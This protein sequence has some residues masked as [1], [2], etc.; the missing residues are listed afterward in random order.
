MLYLL[1]LVDVYFL[2]SPGRN[3]FWENAKALLQS[4]T[5]V[6][7]AQLICEGLLQ[8]NKEKHWAIKTN[9]QI[10]NWTLTDWVS[11]MAQWGPWLSQPLIP[12]LLSPTYIYIY[13]YHYA[14]MKPHPPAP[15]MGVIYGCE[16]LIRQLR[17]NIQ[18]P[19]IRGTGERPYSHQ[20]S[21]YKSK[22]ATV[23]RL[24]LVC[25]RYIVCET[26]PTCWVRFWW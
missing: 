19:F 17:V 15:G 6:E 26:A 10:C 13:I 16:V 9:P 23:N 20:P 2:V 18:Q 1:K 7:L 24:D 4:T 14:M 21:T 11:R 12:P 25:W 22:S 5:Q 3:Y 8:P